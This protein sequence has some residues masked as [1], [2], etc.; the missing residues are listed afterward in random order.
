MRRDERSRILAG[1]DDEK[2]GC[3]LDFGDTRAPR[4]WSCDVLVRGIRCT[5]CDQAIRFASPLS[6]QNCLSPYH[7]SAR[8][9]CSAHDGGTAN[10]AFPPARH[11][12]ADVSSNPCGSAL[13]EDVYRSIASEPRPKWFIVCPGRNGELGDAVADHDR[14]T[15]RRPPRGTTADTAAM[16][17][18]SSMSILAPGRR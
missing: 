11:Y 12:S 8:A 9:C 18:S 1:T 6:P 4:V 10:V 5:P 13:D 3:G 17:P 16:A 15:S 14:A 2:R 7:V